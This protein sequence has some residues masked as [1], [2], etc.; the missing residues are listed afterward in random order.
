MKKFAIML[1]LITLVMA[2]CSSGSEKKVQE[3]QQK[4]AEQYDDLL[5]N[6]E[7]KTKSTKKEAPKK[8]AATTQKSK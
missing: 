7:Q 6:L 5:K 4:G 2:G 1:S 8:E 3:S